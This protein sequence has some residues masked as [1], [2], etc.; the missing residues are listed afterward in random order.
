MSYNHMNCETFFSFLNNNKRCLN[1]KSLNLSGNELNDIFFEK[2]IQNNYNELFDNLE[3]LNLNNNL[4][5][6][7]TD[8]T[9]RD[10]LPLREDYKIYEKKIYK[11][12]L[13]YKFISL[14]KNMKLFS[15]T[16]NPISKIWK[17][18][19][20]INEEEINKNVIKDDNGKIIINC[21]Y[22]LLL[23]IKKE[24]IDINNCKEK[25]NI[26]VE[27]RSSINQDLNNFKFDNDFIIFKNN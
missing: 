20:L 23:K 19:N 16:R 2:Y 24:I 3:I 22:S 12:R 14:N 6:D 18:I 7:D 8:I 5:G 10:D 4:I 9:Y 25:L 21:F 27:C 26:I 11:L 15:I 1:I 13:I 17:I